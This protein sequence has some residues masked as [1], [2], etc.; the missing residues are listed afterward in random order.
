MQLKKDRG[1]S[2]VE[3]LVAIAIMAILATVGFSSYA[4][5]KNK[6]SVEAEVTKL[7][8]TIREA[9]ELSRSQADGSQWGVH[10]ANPTGTGNDFY[11]IWK[12][13][14]YASSTVTSRVNLTTNVRFTDPAD[15]STKDVSFGKSTGLITASSSVVI[16]SL[17]SGGT[18]RVNIDTSGR[19]DY[20][21][22]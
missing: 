2:L 19:V 14:S 1:F 3:L 15:G 5:F 11:E 8:A 22:N 20:T 17:T 12:G 4:G 6:Q 18:G 9:M 10:F 16:E 13:T 7:T 21:L